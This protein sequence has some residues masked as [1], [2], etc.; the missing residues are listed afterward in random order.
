[1]YPVYT[2]VKQVKGKS[3]TR[4]EIPDASTISKIVTVLD[5]LETQPKAT[6]SAVEDIGLRTNPEKWVSSLL[7]G[8]PEEVDTTA[9]E[10]LLFDFTESMQTRMREETK[11]ALALLMENKL[12]LC[13]SI[14]GEETITPEWEIIP[15]MMDVDNVLRYAS[16]FVDEGITCVRYW[17]SSATSSFIEW[18]GL[19]RKQAFQ[20]GG[21]YR[22]IS[23]IEG[24]TVELQLT[25]R[26]IDRWLSDHPEVRNGRI[27]LRGPIRHLSI[28]EIRAGRK[29]YDHTGD[30][31]QDFE[32]RKH[33]VPRY[34]QEYERLRS[35]ALPLLIKYYDEKTQVVS[36]STDEETIEVE[37]TTP[38][39]D[40]VF[41][42]G[43]IKFRASYLSE[44]TLRLLNRQE[45]SVFHAGLEF[46]SEPYTLGHLKVYNNVKISEVSQLV[47]D[48]YNGTNL[49]DNLLDT[50]VR[51]VA[52]QL[53]SSA[54][55]DN[56]MN[57]VLSNVG[58]ALLDEINLDGTLSKLEDDV[59]EY[60]SRD[61][62]SG[63]NDKVIST[64][65]DDVRN[66]LKPHPLAILIVGVED[67]GTIDA[68]PS[69][70][71]GSD[72]LETIREGLARELNIEQVYLSS[73]ASDG[74]NLVLL[75]A[76][77][78]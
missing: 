49:Q 4:K 36:V 45:V 50:I 39:F 2:F 33:G 6:I 70:R 31:I 65:E 51:F 75:V 55:V 18:L 12:F 40:I 69:A 24:V 46:R 26:E 11:Y 63:G 66:A 14:Y 62:F 42:D 72:R 17:E 57:Y 5:R 47:T 10:N 37:K 35:E 20:F 61:V 8:Y 9:A 52:L 71:V 68:L 34:Q 19:P 28:E 38:G 64:L 16:F 1:M 48:Y 54:N 58:L 44:L 29:H 74:G 13:H 43:L 22:I 7:A 59:V 67:D 3:V 21:T 73:I 77:A 76:H 56:P 41:A 30:F 53:M 27:D 25:E 60:K 15:R 23:C 78:E 32:A